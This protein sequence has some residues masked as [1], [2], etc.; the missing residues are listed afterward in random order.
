MLVSRWRTIRENFSTRSFSYERVRRNAA[1]GTASMLRSVMDDVDSSGHVLSQ[2]GSELL[3]HISL[4]PGTNPDQAPSTSFSPQP[5][6]RGMF[7]PWS[8]LTLW[9]LTW[10][11]QDKPYPGVELRINDLGLKS[12]LEIQGP[13]LTL[14][15]VN[16]PDAR[17]NTK[18]VLTYQDKVA[19]NIESNI[20]FHLDNPSEAEPGRDVTG[21]LLTSTIYS[22][23]QWYDW[24]YGL[25]LLER[26][27]ATNYR[28]LG[29]GFVREARSNEFIQR[30]KS[31]KAVESLITCI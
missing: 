9:P 6:P 15:L 12:T 7:P 22:S 4:Y 14:S 21:A 31:E 30:I 18:L 3:W 23:D 11:S 28:R 13:S 27:D 5:A 29:V 16:K 17:G 26:V 2:L 24:R 1:L 8:W 25:L 10:P 20:E 19:S